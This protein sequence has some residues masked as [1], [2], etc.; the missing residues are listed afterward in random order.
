M[1]SPSDLETFSSPPRFR[2][3]PSNTNYTDD[4][5]FGAQATANWSVEC[6]WDCSWKVL[7]D[8]LFLLI[9]FLHHGLH[10]YTITGRSPTFHLFVSATEQ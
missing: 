1:N 9:R 3:T 5:L 7:I 4:P 8:I 6:L 2:W 10:Y